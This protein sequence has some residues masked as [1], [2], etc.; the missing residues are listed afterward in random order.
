MIVLRIGQ[1]AHQLGV[2]RNTIR[3]WIGS[4][5]LPAR[6]MSGKRYLVSEADFDKICRE[7]GIDRSVLKL[8]HIPGAALMSREMGMFEQD[9]RL[10]QGPS[11]KLL[12]K[13]FHVEACTTCGSCASACPI[14]GVDGMDPRKLVRMAMLGLDDELVSSQWPWKCTICGKCETACPQNVE[15]VALV[16]R[17][18]GLRD[19]SAVPGPLH[20]GVVTCI[21]KGNNLGIRKEDFIAIVDEISGEMVEEGCPG[22]TSP[23]DRKGAELL[24][25]LNSKE[26]FAEPDDMKYWWKIFYA[27]GQSWTIPSTGWEGLNWALFTGDDE[28]LK[29]IVGNLVASMYR[30]GCKTLLLPDSGHAYYATRYGLERWFKEDMKN[31]K[32]VSIFDLLIRYI[33]EGKIQLDPSR[34]RRLTTYSDPCHYGRKSLKAFGRGYFEEARKII[35]KCAPRFVDTYPTGDENYCCGAGGGNWVMPFREERIFHGR[36]KAHQIE[37]S[38]AGL[39]VTACHGCRDQI[40]KSLRRE[41]DL[42]VDVKSIWELVADCIVL[43]EKLPFAARSGDGSRLQISGV[44]VRG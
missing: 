36:F 1:L 4:G 16:G 43:P 34:E 35:R 17:I 31:F 9:V 20:K 22:F 14:S 38:K 37:S 18:R 21:E 23:I 42:K 7:F 30:L 39:V 33:E 24:V 12:K 44:E 3:N 25:T 6:S 32:V 26:P 15:I 10:L 29:K 13:D 2:H 19:R 27:A 11:G 8:K 28:S 41:Y 5:R 40:M